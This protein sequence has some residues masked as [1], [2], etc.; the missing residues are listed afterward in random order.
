MITFDDESEKHL[1]IELEDTESAPARI[2]VLGVGGGGSNAVNRMIAA[3][4][5]GIEFIA[6]NTDLQ[7]LRKSIAP[8]KVQ[9]GTRLTKGLGAGADPEIGKNA[10]LEDL[11]KLNALLAGSDMVFI[12]AG[13]GGGTGTGAAPVIAKVAAEQGALT[14]GIVTK[15][16]LFEGGKRMKQAERGMRD[17]RDHVDT[18][19]TVPNQRLLSF[20]ERDTTHLEAFRIADDILRQAI[21]GISDLITSPGEINLDF[22]DVKKIMSDMGRALMGTGVA[23]GENRAVSAAQAAISS[24]LLEDASIDGARGVLMNI[25]GGPDMTLH[26]MNEAA[27]IIQRAADPDAEIIFGCVTDERMAGSVKVTVIATGFDSEHDRPRAALEIDDEP[28]PQPA[29]KSHFMRGDDPTGFGPN[30]SAREDFDIPTVLR[31]QMD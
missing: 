26:E 6:C 12:A 15:P 1:A 14:V 22:A 25:T 2:R 13:L 30:A 27:E 11:D 17:M 23:S 5:R 7:A 9:L 8:H 31:R 18:L 16:F 24:P 4:I 19:I 3:G 10:A 28:E 21:Q 20:V 29:K